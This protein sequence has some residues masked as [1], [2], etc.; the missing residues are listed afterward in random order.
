MTAAIGIVSKFWIVDWPETASFLSDDERVML[1]RKLKEEAGV[2]RMDRLDKRSGKRI[3]LDWKIYLGTFMYMGALV[4]GY[5]TSFFIPT[6]INRKSLSCANQ[7]SWS[8]F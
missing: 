1:L 3:L 5:A 6:I 7:S 8:T 4:T 2:A